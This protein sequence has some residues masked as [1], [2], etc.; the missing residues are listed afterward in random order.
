MSSAFVKGVLPFF[1][2]CG[3]VVLGF[4][5]DDTEPFPDLTFADNFSTVHSSISSNLPFLTEFV[6]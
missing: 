4:A 1:V 2:G 5:A 3:R 6:I